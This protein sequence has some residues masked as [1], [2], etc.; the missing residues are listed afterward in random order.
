MKVEPNHLFTITGVEY[1]NRC[2]NYVKISKRKTTQ[3]ARCSARA[4]VGTHYARAN[5]TQTE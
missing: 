4:I 2:F 3:L 5:K 1:I